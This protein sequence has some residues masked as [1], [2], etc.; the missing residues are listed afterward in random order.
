LHALVHNPDIKH[1]LHS[2]VLRAKDEALATSSGLDRTIRRA[3]SILSRRERE[4]LELLAE[5]LTN[6]EIARVLFIS[7]ATAKI[8]VRHILQKLRVR[9][10]TEAALRLAD[11]LES[12]QAAA[13]EEL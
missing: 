6:K 8:H 12:D 4:V 7:E 10:R 2:I 11:V 3:P 5:G 13:S 9:S 1:Q